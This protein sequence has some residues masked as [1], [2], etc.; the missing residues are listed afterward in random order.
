MDTWLNDYAPSAECMDKQS[1]VQKNG[2]DRTDYA[3]AAFCGG[4]AGLIDILFVQTP[5]ES[6]LQ[7]AVDKSADSLVMKSAQFFWK[8]DKRASG[9][10]KKMPD[11]LEKCIS[12][13]EQA[14]PVPYDARYAK[15]LLVD[16]G[17]L[18]DMAPKNHHLLSLAHSPDPI[19]LVFSII[20]QFSGK[21]SFFDDGKLIRA[22]PRK[23]SGAIPYMVGKSLPEKLFC[24]FLNWIGHI[25]SD[26]SGSSSTRKEGKKGRGMGVQMPFYELFLKCNYEF[27]DGETL[28]QTMIDVYEQGYDLRFGATMAIPVVLEEVMVRTFWTIRRKFVFELPWKEC[29]PTAKH[30]DLRA[31]LLVSNGVFFTIDAADAAVHGL[32]SHNLVDAIC[33]V[34]LVGLTRF[35]LLGIQEIRIRLKVVLFESDADCEKALGKLTSAE[36]KWIAKSVEQLQQ[37]F[38]I[39]G[40][41]RQIHSAQEEHSLVKAERIRLEE[42]LQAALLE[43]STCRNELVEESERR[44]TEYYVA[45]G[46]GFEQIESGISGSDS[47]QVIRGNVTIQQ[48]LGRETQ[49]ESQTEFDELMD[50]DEDFKL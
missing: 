36:T 10:S 28:A 24:G 34:N 23:Q 42:R 35:A 25:L 43:Y 47:E 12:Y 38:S 2:C 37:G 17:V 33:R 31:M 29:I 49:F 27:K 21:A 3:L 4:L 1:P 13:L 6:P 11:T 46:E 44:M 9:K 14:F 5:K 26:I 30:A 20:D 40:V 18:A 22:V 45:I 16:D 50:S 48:A 41:I 19:G 7:N 32:C 15:D 39:L 8:H